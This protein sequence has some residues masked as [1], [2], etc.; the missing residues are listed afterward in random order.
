MA[1]E[2]NR[3]LWQWRHGQVVHLDEGEGHERASHPCADAAGGSLLW[4]RFGLLVWR[5]RDVRTLPQL[6]TSD[7]F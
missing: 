2:V 4:S 5:S 3:Y 7:S 6:C 1:V